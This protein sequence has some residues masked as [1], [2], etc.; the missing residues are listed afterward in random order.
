MG[1]RQIKSLREDEG[2]WIPA[3]RGNGYREVEDLWRRAGVGPRALRVLAEADALA[4]MGLNRREAIWE[5][6]AVGGSAPLPLFSGDI[7]GEGIVE[8]AAHLP[9]MTEGEEVVED[10]VSMR[11]TLRAHPMSFLRARLTP[12]MGRPAQGDVLP[13]RRFGEARGLVRSDAWSMD[14]ESGGKCVT[15]RE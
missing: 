6:K 7:D 9:Q 3:A 5:A 13:G 12:G 10:Y 15:V 8:P 4:S 1:F 2:R 14:D 11:L